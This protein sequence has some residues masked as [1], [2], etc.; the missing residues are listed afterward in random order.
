MESGVGVGDIIRLELEEGGTWFY[1]RV[2]ELDDT[3][4]VFS[5]V[6]AQSWP[7]VALGGYLPGRE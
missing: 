5:V 3:D 6:D 4:V 1:C 2:R 7:S